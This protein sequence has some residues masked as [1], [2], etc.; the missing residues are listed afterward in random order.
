MAPLLTRCTRILR[1]P[2]AT[3]ALCTTLVL[4]T[5]AAVLSPH[6]ARGGSA[7]TPVPPPMP[8]VT[9][10]APVEPP[11]SQGVQLKTAL[12]Q[13][14]VL[15]GSNGAVYVE[16][17]MTTP[18]LENSTPEQRPSDV[19]VVLDRSGSMAADNKLPYAKEAVR[20]LVGRLQEQDRFA[21]VTFDTSAMVQI[22]LSPLTEGTRAQIL[23]QVQS[24]RPG[25][26]T[27]IGD[28]LLTARALLEGS[29]AGG[30]R[31]R[32]VILLSDGE[33][34]VGVVD[35]KALGTIAASFRQHEAVLSSIGMGLEF[36]ETL[37]A[38]LADHGMGHYGYLEHLAKLGEI[39]QSDLS[40]ARQV[41][42]SA[43]HIEFAL[44]NSVTLTDAGGYPVETVQ[45]GVVR[46]S[47]GQLLAGTPK[48]F[49]VTLQVPTAQV[50]DVRLGA[51]TLHYTT[52]QGPAHLAF[53]A[54]RL[55]VAVLEP[56]RRDEAV[57]SIDQPLQR[58]IWDTNNLGRAQKAVSDGLRSGDKQKAKAA[59]T[60]YREELNAAE[61]SAG[62]PMSSPETVRKL[63]DL[64]KDVDEAFSGSVGEQAVKRNRAA[65]EQH[66]GSMKSQRY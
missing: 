46:V 39:L 2:H 40:D 4:G 65:K 31:S 37:M 47:T 44:G 5:A 23:R 51:A 3:I 20:A 8:T 27:N 25:A 10:P 52:G 55:Q 43:S 45:P 11:T 66:K 6:L 16:L 63:T 24:L 48:R 13:S 56:T 53:P 38:G 9:P 32:R 41:Y 30:T 59:I 60:Q 26:S 50:G 12:A 14:K 64:E 1:S 42:A 57:A 28:G 19:I 36:N 61:A 21:L 58:Q 34:N 33:T 7:P 54:E 49:V 15:Q 29:G 18:R 62:A 35:P 22:P 17:T